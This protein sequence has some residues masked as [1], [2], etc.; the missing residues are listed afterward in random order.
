MAA[1]VRQFP[2]SPTPAPPKPDAT[3][4]IPAEAGISVGQSARPAPLATGT[5]RADAT[6]CSPRRRRS[7]HKPG[8]S[9]AILGADHHPD[10]ALLVPVFAA[11]GRDLA[12]GTLSAEGMPGQVKLV[13][14]G[15]RAPLNP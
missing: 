5:A 6:R 14:F 9:F 13:P 11:T 4:V 10:A 12:T 7:A 3:P 8:A 15:Q 1:S 2:K